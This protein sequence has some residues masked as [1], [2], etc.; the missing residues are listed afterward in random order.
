MKN[1]EHKA[2][3]LTEALPYIEKYKNKVIVV[4][5]GGNAM[6]DETIK[7]SVMKD[8]TLLSSLG[9]QV[10]L[11]H[12]GGPEINAMLKR[13]GKQPEF[14][15]GLRYTDEETLEIA[16]M[17]LMGKVNK[18]LVSLIH[19]NK[20]KGIGLSGA[21]GGLIQAKK[22]TGEIDYGFVGDIIQINQEPVRAVLDKGYIPVIA[23]IGVDAQGQLYN[24]NGDTAAAAIA[25]AMG[26]EKLIFM[27]DIPGILRDVTDEAS[28][29]PCL[30]IEE[31]DG[32]M[33]ENII[34]GGM[35][36]KVESCASAIRQGLK[37]AVI[38]DGRREHSI[39]QELFS[40]ETLGTS[41]VPHTSQQKLED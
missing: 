5:Y 40:E 8:L 41:I 14:I 12:G 2:K 39:L 18:N 17:V 4:K 19:S 34:T 26:A 24:I 25:G 6:I 32:F 16:G 11:V 36:P 30:F 9:I 29:I 21:D 31:I 23:T 28:L 10:V 7:R 27:T 22:K 33:E 35:I 3:A 37:E 13:V 38:L 15:K 1:A 20:G